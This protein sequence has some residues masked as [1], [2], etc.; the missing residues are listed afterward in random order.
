MAEAVS[1]T[2]RWRRKRDP[3]ADRLLLFT[4]P[5]GICCTPLPSSPPKTEEAT[6]TDNP[7]DPTK[8]A[9]G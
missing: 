5:K 2:S 6:V 4:G 8:E 3:E 1:R 7:K 9:P